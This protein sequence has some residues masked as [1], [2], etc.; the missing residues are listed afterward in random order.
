M[1]EDEIID[2]IHRTINDTHECED[3]DEININY[4][5]V[6]EI[7]YAIYLRY[8]GTNWPLL[9]LM[10]LS[11]TKVI[12]IDHGLKGGPLEIKSEDGNI[13][14]RGRLLGQGNGSI[15]Y[16]YSIDPPNFIGKV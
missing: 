5:E 8:N 6:N 14:M 7:K 10:N 1:T 2:I 13:L 3:D 16:K 4:I 11:T 9:F 12:E 15:W